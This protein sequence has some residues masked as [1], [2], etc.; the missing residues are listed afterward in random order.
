[1]SLTRHILIALALSGAM[2]GCDRRPATPRASHVEIRGHRWFVDLALTVEDRYTGLSGRQHLPPDVGMLFVYPQANVLD[3]CMRGCVAEIDI[4]FI[5]ADR[6]VV[7]LYTMAVEP[8]RA[9]RVSYS[10]HSPAQYA[11]EVAGGSFRRVGVQVGDRVTFSAGIPPPA[12][13][14]AGP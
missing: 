14:E 7:R 1:M 6:R 5:D 3:F 11:L 10:S 4:A 2:R 9:G 12:K 8:D 13:A